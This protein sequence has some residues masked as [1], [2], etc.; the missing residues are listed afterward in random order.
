MWISFPLLI[1][2]DGSN[3]KSKIPPGPYDLHNVHE[4]AP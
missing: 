4:N 2:C 1:V 3:L